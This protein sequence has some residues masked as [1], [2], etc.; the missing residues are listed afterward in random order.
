MIEPYPSP[1]LEVLIMYRIKINKDF[2][3]RLL[4]HS[5]F[6]VSTNFRLELIEPSAREV[7]SRSNLTRLETASG[8]KK[9]DYPRP[10]YQT[11]LKAP[12]E[13]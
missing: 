13:N 8:L 6:Q 11:A 3:M 7:K 10:L 9:T 4:N 5:V 1:K 12:G 2:L